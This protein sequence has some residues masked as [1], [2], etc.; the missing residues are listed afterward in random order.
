[1][2]GLIYTM[3]VIS[4]FSGFSF[5]RKDTGSESKITYK[6]FI[7]RE[8]KS[9]VFIAYKDSTGYI[10]EITD[11]DWSKEVTL[12]ADGLASLLAIRQ[13]DAEECYRTGVILPKSEDLIEAKIQTGKRTITG[14]GRKVVSITFMS[15]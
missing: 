13:L 7:D 12:P 3:L 14:H 11:K 8:N 1:M 5:C 15:K 9:N 4:V 6:I 2:K 10:T